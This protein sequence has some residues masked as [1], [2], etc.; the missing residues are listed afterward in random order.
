MALRI[1][2]IL[3]QQKGDSD[4]DISMADL[5]CS[6]ITRMR[7]RYGREVDVSKMDLT[8]ADPWAFNLWG[9]QK[10]GELSIDPEDRKIQYDFW[11]RYIGNSRSRLALTFRRFFLPVA[12]Y[13]KNPELAVENKIP[14]TELRKL[15]KELPDEGTLTEEDQKSLATLRRFLDGEFKDGIGPTGYL[16]Q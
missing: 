16:Y 1:V 3:T 6:F 11:L 2:T 4:L 8:T 5:Y 10:V 14:M 12:V 9:S 13:E 15:D 7:K